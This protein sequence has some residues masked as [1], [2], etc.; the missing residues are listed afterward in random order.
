M[1]RVQ[2]IGTSSPGSS[3][4]GHLQG[5]RARAHASSLT[6]NKNVSTTSFASS[7]PAHPRSPAYLHANQSSSSLS[8]WSPGRKNF[9]KKIV[10]IG[11]PT[12]IEHGIHVEYNPERRKFMGIPDVWQNEVPTDDPLDTTCISPHLVPTPR[13]NSQDEHSIGWPYNVQHKAHVDVDVT[14][15]G[16][17]GLKGLP[18]EW[19]AVLE[20]QGISEQEIKQHPQALQKLMQLQLNDLELPPPSR[21]P[22][23]PPKPLP[24]GMALNI[25]PRSPDPKSRQQ[26]HVSSIQAKMDTTTNPRRTSS[27]NPAG[28]PPVDQPYP[29]KLHYPQTRPSPAPRSNSDNWDTKTVVASRSKLDY[30]PGT[31]RESAGGNGDYS[32]VR[33]HS[34]G[35]TNTEISQNWKSSSRTSNDSESSTRTRTAESVVSGHTSSAS[36]EGPADSTSNVN[37]TTSCSNS[38]VK[39]P[40]SPTF[41]NGTSVGNRSPPTSTGSG[42]SSFRSPTDSNPLPISSYFKDRSPTPLVTKQTGASQDASSPMSPP[43]SGSA[44]AVTPQHLRRKSVKSMYVNIPSPAAADADAKSEA[45]SRTDTLSV[46]HDER[47]KL[48]PTLSDDVLRKYALEAAKS[49]KSTVATFSEAS[50]A[51]K[52][53]GGPTPNYDL[54]DK[55]DLDFI[56]EYEL[57][58]L[59]SR[60]RP[61][62]PYDIYKDVV[63]IAEGDS[64]FL[65]SATENSTSNLVVVK[66]IARTVT[67]KMKTIRNELE[68]MKAS[69]HQNIVAFVG[70]HLTPT[71]L[72]MVMER[73][74]ISLADVI[75]INPYQG[76]RHPDQGL[77]QECHMAR[78]ARDIL[79]AVAY[80]HQH[81]RIHRDI[82]SDNILLDSQGRV[83]LADFGHSVQLTKEQ[84]RRNSVVGT[85]YWMAPEVIRGFNYGTSVDVW[86]LGIVMREMLD[87]E[88]PFLNEPPLRAMFLIASGDLPKI[89]H[90]TV[91]SKRC[92]SFV[93]ACTAGEDEDRMTAQDLMSHPFLDLA[94][95]A[96]VMSKLLSRT[97]ELEAGE[98]EMSEM[99]EETGSEATA[100]G[101]AE[102][103]QEQPQQ[104]QQQQLPQQ[105]N[106][107]HQQQPQ[108]QNQQQQQQQ[109]PQTLAAV[110]EESG[111]NSHEIAIVTN[112]APVSLPAPVP[113]APTAPVAA[114][115]VVAP[116]TTP[117]PVPIPVQAGDKMSL[118]DSDDSDDDIVIS[119]ATKMPARSTM[120]KT[121]PNSPALVPATRP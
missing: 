30:P 90:R 17:V 74:D 31:G 10:N 64:G 27:L 8:Q 53:E 4:T 83:K 101:A 96:T 121:F 105:H 40:I 59:L 29:S 25:A 65:F 51:I 1:A 56:K 94:C 117:A 45:G 97:Y 34:A 47:H 79:E 119:V 89:R 54:E 68:L 39:V 81:Q 92:M 115:T 95:D 110:E 23:P 67:T 42:S 104:Q 32:R 33:T 61:K 91:A 11:K 86:S 112:N 109:Q 44:G 75:A 37:M 57:Q 63:K 6:V 48:M 76:Q 55:D 78:V 60:P 72:W 12:D 114:A 113:A 70:C 98:D 28:R 103:R 80:L 84:P 99:N 36:I 26:M 24:N 14:G 116:T 108:H 66:I 118:S 62:D 18:S 13:P 9:A 111:Y 71:D 35:A 88:P 2:R 69:H 20:E 120:G 41:S 5:Y 93:E 19:K 15:S 22:P 73:M 49:T 77:L 46:E 21:P 50:K 3:T 85:P 102:S 52:G 82:R 43:T 107:E 58:P 16:K 38:Q 87:G 106:Q 100:A 7:A